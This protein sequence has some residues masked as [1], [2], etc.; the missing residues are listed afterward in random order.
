MKPIKVILANRAAGAFWSIEKLFFNVAEAFPEWVSSTVVTAPRQRANLGSLL[1]NLCW[2]RSLKDC[3]LI[4]QTG[5]IHYAIL[6]QR[7][8]PVVLTIHDL[9]FIEEA[10]GLK[11][12]L[13]WWLWLYLPCRRA[14]RVTV[15][16]E[17]T[18]T[19]LLA[20]CSVKAEKIRVIPNCV[21]PEFTF[22]PNRRPVGKPR[23]LQIGTT[24]NKNLD[25]L[26]EACTGLAIQLCI[27]GKPT[28]SQRAQLDRRGIDYQCFSDL[29]KEAV[30]ELYVTCDLVVFVSTYEGFG[31]PILEAQA[32]GRPVL[33]SN[34]SPMREV[35]GGGALLVDP[36]KVE[37]IRSGMLRLLEDAQL[38][39]TLVVAGTN[40]VRR[41]SAKAIAEQYA[42]IYCEVMEKS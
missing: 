34:L 4:H 5:D 33:T 11:R 22:K 9:R 35:A 6:G 37:A 41:Y 24:D 8:R 2:L 32:V 39:E 13:F 27:L 25:R 21:A 18:K 17:F 28:K 12:I 42:A 31:L 29:T 16:S 26:S 15:I 20:L 19:R 40:N 23:L 30:V 14:R 36:F 7:R 3:D 1:T 38:R 10:R